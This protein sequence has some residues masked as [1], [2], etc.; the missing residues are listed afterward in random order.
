[1]ICHKWGRTF[2]WLLLDLTVTGP[3]PCRVFPTTHFIKLYIC[4]LAI[5]RM[6]QWFSIFLRLPPLSPAFWSVT[7]H[8]PFRPVPLR[9]YIES[10]RSAGELGVTLRNYK[11]MVPSAV[12]RGRATGHLFQW[13]YGIEFKTKRKSN[14]KFKKKLILSLCR[15]V[16]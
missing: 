4:I 9:Q 3:V 7:M 10:G 1:M 6:Y 12:G 16:L 5:Q 11:C 8:H 15:H 2:L 13:R 14:N